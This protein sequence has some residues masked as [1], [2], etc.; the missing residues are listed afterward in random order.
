MRLIDVVLWLCNP[1]QRVQL[2]SM[3]FQHV[4]LNAARLLSV[5][6]C[7]LPHKLQQNVNNISSQTH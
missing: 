4:A 6:C 7:L 2:L 5:V 3:F 1:H